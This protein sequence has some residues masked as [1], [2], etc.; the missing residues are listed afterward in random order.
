M[1]PPFNVSPGNWTNEVNRSIE[2]K[3]TRGE[4]NLQYQVAM[5]NES[6]PA[7]GCEKSFSSSYKC[8]AQPK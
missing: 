8:G 1:A 5:G 7:S 6:D 4:N 3:V 2:G